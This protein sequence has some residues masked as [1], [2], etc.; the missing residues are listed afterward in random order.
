IPINI[1]CEGRT[2]LEGR[3]LGFLDYLVSTCNYHDSVLLQR[4]MFTFKYKRVP[5]LAARLAD[6]IIV[7]GRQEIVLDMVVTSVPLH[8][9]RRFDRGFN[10]ST[11]LARR[12]ASVLDL[13]YCNLLRRTRDTG[14]QAW[15]SR[16]QR[17]TSMHNAF[18]VHRG[19]TVPR[20]VVLIDDIATTGATL[21][22]CAKA[23]KN[24]GAARVD[25]WVIA[26]G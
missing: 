4:A 26:R 19:R 23:L 13:P 15:R 22:A 1:Y 9:Q 6:F 21:D 12:T 2:F 14:H 25:A 11:L 17:M 10:Q 18:V 16:E 8:W 5:G 24:A 20:H 7:A 3:G